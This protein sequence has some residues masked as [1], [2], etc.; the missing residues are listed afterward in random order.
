MGTGFIDSPSKASLVALFAALVLQLSAARAQ[1]TSVSV[2]VSQLDRGTY[3]RIDA[4]NL[5]KQVVVRLIQEGFAV[6]SATERPAIRVD[7]QLQE[8]GALA[9]VA[10]AAGERRL[11]VVE[12]SPSADLAAL[13][14][15]ISQKSVELVR[16][17]EAGETGIPSA[18]AGDPVP[19]ERGPPPRRAP[20][21]SAQIGGVARSAVDL[22][23]GAG[24][25][26]PLRPK[27]SLSATL[28]FVPASNSEIDVVEWQALVGVRW[29]PLGGEAWRVSVGADFGMLVH[30]YQR[31]GDSG[32]RAD[33]LVLIPLTV[34][35]W[36]SDR[37]CLGARLAPGWAGESREHKSGNDSIWHRSFARLELL[38][39]AGWRL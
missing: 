34:E 36:L 15:E 18:E 39:S 21:V 3:K 31:A 4:L 33:L 19:P 12:L 17:L 14:L 38:F 22:Y 32:A 8:P 28:G 9:I 20:R 5:E 2:D 27:L 25:L 11:S 6:V 26:Y 16:Q 7:Y 1:P 23:I 30:H 29:G 24:G 13:H 37:L 10:R 35:R